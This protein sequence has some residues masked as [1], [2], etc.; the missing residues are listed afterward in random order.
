MSK[1]QKVD[2]NEGT[3]NFWIPIDLFEFDDKLSHTLFDYSDTNGSIRVVKGNDNKLKFIHIITG[4]CRT[5]V[6]V[7]V[8]DLS[9]KDQHMITATWSLSSKETNIYVD[10]NV[11]TAKSEIKY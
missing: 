8:S 11:K 1:L 6:E 2:L 5:N 10:G 4:K 7:D 9:S 3:L